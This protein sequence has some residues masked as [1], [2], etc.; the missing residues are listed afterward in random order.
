MISDE[1]IAAMNHVRDLF[2]ELDTRVVLGLRD[3]ETDAHRAYA[4]G[5]LSEN[6]GMATNG[7]FNILSVVEAYELTPVSQAQL[8]NEKET[9]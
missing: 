1:E 6:I 3:P 8:H 7:I 5:K 2:E 4:L 9:A